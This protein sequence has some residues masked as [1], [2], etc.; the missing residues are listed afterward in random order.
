MILQALVPYTSNSALRWFRGP[1]RKSDKRCIPPMCRRQKAENNKDKDC[2][3][4][5]HVLQTPLILRYSVKR[6]NIFTSK[7]S[8]SHVLSLRLS[9]SRR[10]HICLKSTFV[11]FTILSRENM[12]HVLLTFPDFQMHFILVSYKLSKFPAFPAHNITA[13]I[14]EGTGKKKKKASRNG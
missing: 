8:L 12:L 11:L 10:K 7:T 5:L 4:N 1:K 2:T 9:L 3:A 6:K 13:F 14:N